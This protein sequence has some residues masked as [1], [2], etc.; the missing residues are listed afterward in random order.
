MIC[1]FADDTKWGGV[2]DTP[3][4]HT[5]LQRNISGWR[6][7]LNEPHEVQREDV[8]SL[9]PGEEQTHAP[10]HGKGHPTLR[11]FGRRGPKGLGEHQVEYE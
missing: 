4:G 1:V 11:Q 9:V 7:G 8:Q 2:G 6:N 10:L 3:E 5:A